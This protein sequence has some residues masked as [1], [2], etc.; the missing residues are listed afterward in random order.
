[1]NRSAEI[2]IWSIRKPSS[3]GCRRSVCVPDIVKVI[4]RP[5]TPLP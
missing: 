5:M 4:G 2:T 1:M 3:R